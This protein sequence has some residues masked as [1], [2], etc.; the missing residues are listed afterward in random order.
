M[1]VQVQ[2]WI[3]SIY[4]CVHSWLSLSRGHGGRGSCRA[5]CTVRREINHAGGRACAAQLRVAVVV[6]AAAAAARPGPASA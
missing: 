2:R 3:S 4:A 1:Q 6:E 5:C